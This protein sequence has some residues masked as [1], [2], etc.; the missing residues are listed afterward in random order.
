M[1]NQN[2]RSCCSL[3]VDGYLA[4]TY[5]DSQYPGVRNE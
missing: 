3:F 2:W 1:D 4:M 5:P